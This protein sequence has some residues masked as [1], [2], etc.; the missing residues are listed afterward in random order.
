MDWRNG[1]VCNYKEPLYKLQELAAFPS[2][3]L[4]LRAE[5][6]AAADGDGGDQLTWI[7]TPRNVVARSKNNIYFIQAF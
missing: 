3:L 5:A 2:S 6:A 4:K 1:E 7:H